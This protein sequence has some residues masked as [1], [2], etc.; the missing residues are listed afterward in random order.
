M[1]R[2]SITDYKDRQKSEGLNLLRL[3]S[4]GTDCFSVEFRKADQWNFSIENGLFS[5]K[6]ST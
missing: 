2:H 1:D 6:P 5:A 4:D 3:A